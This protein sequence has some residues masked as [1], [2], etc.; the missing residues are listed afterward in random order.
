MKVMREIMSKF[1]GEEGVELRW[2]GGGG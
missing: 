1:L 2:G